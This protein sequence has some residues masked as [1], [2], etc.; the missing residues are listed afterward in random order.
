VR[1]IR[2]VIALVALAALITAPKLVGA[3]SDPLAWESFIAPATLTDFFLCRKS[4]VA[5]YFP[6]V[7]P[8]SPRPEERDSGRDL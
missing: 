1:I 8:L 2:P 6:H 7:R 4:Q 5:L 3:A